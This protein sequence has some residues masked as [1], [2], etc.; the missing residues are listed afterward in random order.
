MMKKS[1]E[2]YFFT[3]RATIIFRSH[4]KNLLNLIDEAIKDGV[5]VI[6]NTKVLSADI[7]NGKIN[8]VKCI[9]TDTSKEK[10]IDIE[11]SEFYLQADSII[12]A[13]GLKPKT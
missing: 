12:F 4:A 5:E 13:I 1:Q 3:E 6:Y 8:K 10:V 9:K 2:K 7:K 11:N